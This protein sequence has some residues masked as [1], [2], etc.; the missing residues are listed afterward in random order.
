MKTYRQLLVILFLFTAVRTLAQ[1]DTT[2]HIKLTGFDRKRQIGVALGTGTSN[3]KVTNSNWKQRTIDY[4]D[5]L[6]SIVSKSV[7]K[8][9]LSILY[10]INFNKNFAFRPTITLSFE[11]GKVQYNKHQSVETVD[12]RTVSETVSL[13]LLLKFRGKS[14]QPYILVGPTFLFMLGQD[15]T[16]QNHLPL[17]SFDVLGDAG[18]GLDIDAPIIKMIVTPEVKFSR[19]LLNQKGT[20]NDLYANTIERLRRHYFTFTI[21]LRDR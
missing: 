16:L 18:I 14:M 13:P 20:A 3:F 10:L 9:D 19:G 21:Y 6:K 2:K 11:G 15:D 8:F 17:K 7:F 4:N 5:S 12:L 1:S